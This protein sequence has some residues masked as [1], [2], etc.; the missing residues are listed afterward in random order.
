MGISNETDGIQRCCEAISSCSERDPCQS[1]S[2]PHQNFQDPHQL[3]ERSRAGLV[4]IPTYTWSGS[5]SVRWGSRLNS[6]GSSKIWWGSIV[7]TW[8]DPH[9]D[10]VGIPTKVARDPFNIDRDPFNFGRD[11]LFLPPQCCTQQYTTHW[12]VR[13][14][15]LSFKM[16]TRQDAIAGFEVTLRALN[17]SNSC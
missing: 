3:S 9:L 11:S 5:L 6:E 13:C 14:E 10:L 8:R 4:G 12:H 16:Q 17:S 15:A 7:V 2:D 1:R